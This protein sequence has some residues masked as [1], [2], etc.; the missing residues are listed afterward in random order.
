MRITALTAFLAATP[1]AAEAFE[2]PIPQPQSA[3]AELWFALASVALLAAL[4]AVHRLV[5]RR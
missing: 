3:T 2:Q 4:F 1:A 5:M